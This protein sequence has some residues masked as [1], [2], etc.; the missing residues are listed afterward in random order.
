M[1]L[2][3]HNYDNWLNITNSFISKVKNLILLSRIKSEKEESNF[4]KEVII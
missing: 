3:N 4:N 2:L 1:A